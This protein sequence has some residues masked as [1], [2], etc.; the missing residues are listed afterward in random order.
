MTALAGLVTSLALGQIVVN[1]TMRDGVN[2]LT[3]V[4][5]DTGKK[6]TVVF[7][8]SPYVDGGYLSLAEGYAEELGEGYCSVRQEMRGTNGR[9]TYDM[10]R[11]SSNDTQDT[12]RWITSQPWSTGA[13][14]QTGISADAVNAF[15]SSFG[16]AK[17][18]AIQKQFI[19]WGSANAHTSLYPSMAYRKYLHETWLARTF[20][21][22]S[23]FLISETVNH[24]APGTWWDPVN[25]TA[26]CSTGYP[27]VI[28]GGWYD[29]F[30][31]GT[32]EGYAC[33]G[34]SPETRLVIEP[35]GH[36]GLSGCP[37]YE[38][39]YSNFTLK[40]GLD[41]FKGSA[42]DPIFKKVTFYVL[43]AGNDD[44]SAPDRSAPGNYWTSLDQFPTP[45]MTDFY[46]TSANALASSMEGDDKAFSYVYRPEEPAPTFGGDNI[47]LTC[48]AR[49]QRDIE[50]RTDVI[51]FTSMPL[52]SELAITGE[53]KATLYVESNRTDTDFTAVLTDVYP[54]GRSLLIKE[55]IV[56]MRW[57]NGVTGGAYPQSITP[58]TVYKVTVRLSITSYVFAPYHKFRLAV[59]S[60]NSPRM[61]ANPNTGVPLNQ[62]SLPVPAQNTIHVGPAHPSYLTLPVVQMSQIPRIDVSRGGTDPAGMRKAMERAAMKLL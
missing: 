9:G 60:S 55:G 7:E 53:I 40:M 26:Q 48:G 22:Q 35:C 17:P 32:V 52:S 34:K 37:I 38:M 24:E 44:G 4:G 29:I 41:L 2:L 18:S 39:E 31:D 11:S 10:M 33:Y 56:R 36:C 13:V 27:A 6:Q 21:T 23:S 51:V 30:I 19:A 8:V 43:G 61:S 57:M 50:S 42:I 59:S 12:I 54:D 25:A 14:F 47:Y 20:P 49:D 5:C 62:N 28:L 1:V 58:N 45:E 15:L 16:P 3:H 46:L